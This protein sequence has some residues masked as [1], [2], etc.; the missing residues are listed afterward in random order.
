M[1]QSPPLKSAAAATRA[2][3]AEVLAKAP[4]RLEAKVASQ[5][6]M[7]LLCAVEAALAAILAKPTVQELVWLS[8]APRPGVH[9]LRLQAFG[10]ENELLAEAVHQFEG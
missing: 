3:V 8:G 4:S 10:P 1:S 2:A 6:G 9:L 7:P 5:D